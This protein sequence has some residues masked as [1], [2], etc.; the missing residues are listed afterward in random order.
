M[1]DGGV[2]KIAFYTDGTANH[3][4]SGNVG[5]GTDSRC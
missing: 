5:I 1:Y 3:I 2:E 4:S